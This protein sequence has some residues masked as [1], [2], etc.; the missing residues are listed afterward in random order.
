MNWFN[1]SGRGSVQPA[2]V[3]DAEG[4]AMNGV[5]VMYEPGKIFSAGGS[6]NYEETPAH[7]RAHLILIDKPYE[8]P[9]VTRLPDLHH[10]RT[11]ANVVVLPDGKILVT[12]GQ[13]AGLSFRDEGWIA[14]PE[15]F[16]PV[17]KTFTLLAPASVPR[18][19]HSM[20]LLLPD[21]RVFSGGS[22]LCEYQQYVSGECTG[23]HD[24]ADAQI[25]SP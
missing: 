20:S 17:S 11:Y 2:G 12:G 8:A 6:A 1:V 21:G 4:D 5:H 7:P 16:D 9:A 24:H 15:L 25:F 22:G 10:A 14:E 13:A 23:E 19:Y 18:V 3:R